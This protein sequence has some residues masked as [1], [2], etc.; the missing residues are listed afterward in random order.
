MMPLWRKLLI[1]IALVVI[2]LWI[3]VI[4]SPETMSWLMP[5]AY[6]FMA[7]MFL[8]IVIKSKELRKKY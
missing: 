6:F 3:P 7:I 2:T 4:L 1:I 8:I 5:I